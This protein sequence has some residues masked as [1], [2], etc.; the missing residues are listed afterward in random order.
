M[1]R[2]SLDLREVKAR[3]PVSLPLAVPV[4]L[5][6]SLDDDAREAP[7]GGGSLHGG[8]PAVQTFCSA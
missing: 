1:E 7:L 3:I 6:E 5:R 8:K 4:V 2:D